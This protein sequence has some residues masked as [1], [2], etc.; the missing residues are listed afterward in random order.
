MKVTV[1]SNADS[2]LRWPD[3]SANNSGQIQGPIQDKSRKW[4]KVGALAGFAAILVAAAGV[5]FQ[6]INQ[7]SRVQVVL[8]PVGYTVKSNSDGQFITARIQ[9]CKRIVLRNATGELEHDWRYRRRRN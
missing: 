8:E 9:G 3:M 6:Y 1:L 4:A 7:S 5:F 2:R